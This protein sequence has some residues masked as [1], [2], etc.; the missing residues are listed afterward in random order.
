MTAG[1]V[2]V[3]AA[4]NEEQFIE[5]TIRSVVAQTWRP[6]EWNI[7]SDAS[8]DRTPEIVND[9][10]SQYHFIK[11]VRITEDHP[12]NFA[13]QVNAI[14]IGIRDLRNSG[15]DFFG[16][17]DADISFEPGYFSQLLRRFLDNH[18]LGLAGGS[19]YERSEAGQFRSRKR[20]SLRSVA[21]ACQFFRRECFQ[22]IGGQ[23]LSLPYGAPDVYAEIAARMKGW[24]VASFSDLPVYHYRL[25]GSADHYLRNA[26]RQ[27]RADYS[28]GTLPLFELL[29]VMRRAVDR[30]Y[31]VGSLARLS[32]FGYGYCIGQRR[33]VSADFIRYMRNEQTHRIM[34]PLN[35][36]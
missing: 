19:I 36:L 26:F 10:A 6:L 5:N 14:N 2:L 29:R 11:L 7:V 22:E 24:Q 25:T 16:N 9:Y 27:G 31:I 28:L 1:Y 15:A 34:R 4:Y 33:P 23:Y 12:R 21:H 13:A 8:S 3:T 18:Q 30:P 20:N 17:V 32:G 35:E